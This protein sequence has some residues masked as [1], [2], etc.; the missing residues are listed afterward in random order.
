[1]GD[2]NEEHQKWTK[3]NLLF[4]K[5]EKILWLLKRR[6]RKGSAVSLLLLFFFLLVFYKAVNTSFTRRWL[7]R[8]GVRG[9]ILVDIVQ[10]REEGRPKLNLNKIG[11]FV[12]FGRQV[13]KDTV[14]EIFAYGNADIDVK[15]FCLMIYIYFHKL[16]SPLPLLSS[17][18]EKML[19]AKKLTVKGVS[20]YYQTEINKGGGRQKILT[21]I[22]NELEIAAKSF[23]T[24]KGAKAAAI[25]LLGNCWEVRR[26]AS[27][28]TIRKSTLLLLLKH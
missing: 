28:I 15:V 25:S 2:G 21:D 4:R 1:M 18:L 24:T 17:T 26:I 8:K 16:T 7:T 14:D 20:S 12:E 19:L 3:E 27:S 23:S 11:L 6:E 10:Q 5:K 22:K 9:C 13:V